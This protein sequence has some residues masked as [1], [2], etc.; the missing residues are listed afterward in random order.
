MRVTDIET[1]LVLAREP[2]ED[3]DE[4][5]DSSVNY[6]H[7]CL[8]RVCTDEGVTGLGEATAPGMERATEMAVHDLGRHVVGRDPR[9]VEGLWDRVYNGYAWNWGPV[10]TTALSG[11]EMALWDI[12]GKYH[13]A[14][15]CDLLG[16]ARSDRVKVYANGAWPLE[17]EPK[18]MARAVEDRYDRGYD[19][20]K[21]DPFYADGERIW[22][23]DR[24][25]E[26]AVDRLE[27]VRD[28]VGD[29]VHVGIESHGVA[30]P[31][32]AT[33]LAELVEPYDPLWIEEPVPPENQ[34]AMRR[35]RDR[36]D[37]PIATGERLL[38]TFDYRDF[39]QHPTPA[40][41]VQP[42]VNNCGGISQLKK[43]AAMAYNEYV[44]VAPHNSRGPVATA[45]AA[46]ASATIPNFFILE[47]FPDSPPW[48]Q[49]LIKGEERVEDG[50]YHLPDGPG[51]GVELNEDALKEYPY[52]K[53]EQATVTYTN[54]YRELW[55]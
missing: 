42:D 26:L 40:D 32:A 52:R 10:S 51:L 41:I 44:P 17:S 37:V 25:R 7:Y 19:V 24:Q 31:Q 9:N 54:G 34:D 13:D 23:T 15:V 53:T 4:E 46:H 20:V 36:V 47:Y 48:R 28:A 21:V 49:E 3:P 30:A 39:F 55:S 16:G 12:V 45:A 1:D 27:A 5:R 11:I 38:T 29:D 35:I 18:A 6:W 33:E 14:R 8:V 50:Y 43:I 2:P 22:P